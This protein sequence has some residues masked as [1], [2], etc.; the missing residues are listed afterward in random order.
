MLLPFVNILQTFLLCNSLILRK[1]YIFHK[2][3]CICMILNN[4]QKINVLNVLTVKIDRCY[5]I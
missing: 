5:N 4:I 3:A 1:N 2:T